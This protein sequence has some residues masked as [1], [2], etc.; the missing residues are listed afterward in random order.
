M[1]DA[2]P[3]NQVQRLQQRCDKIN[4]LYRKDRKNHSLLQG[5]F[6]FISIVV[7]KGKTN[8][9]SFS[10]IRI[11]REKAKRLANNMKIRLSQNMISIN[12]T[13]AFPAQ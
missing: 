8:G 12:P 5:D 6:L 10:I 1:G 2:I 11:K 13:G 3:L 7:G 4:A 9:L